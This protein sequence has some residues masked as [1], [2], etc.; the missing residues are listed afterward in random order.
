MPEAMSSISSSPESVRFGAAGFEETGGAGGEE[1]GVRVGTA[2]KE[3]KEN[4]GEG[5]GMKEDRMWKRL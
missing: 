1:R 5:V 3:G 4:E 2:W